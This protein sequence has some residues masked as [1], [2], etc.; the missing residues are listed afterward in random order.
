MTAPQAACLLALATLATVAVPGRA[1]EWQPVTPYRP[2][3]SS[4]AQLPYPGQLE[5]ELGGLATK[6]DGEHRNSLPYALKLAFNDN[7]GVVVGG[8]A[9]V[10]APD[11]GGG[12]T[13]GVGDTT[14]VLK[15]AWLIDSATAFGMELGAKAPT[16][17]DSIGSGRA[18]YSVNGI[19]SRD[20]D[21]VHMDANLNLTRLGVWEDGSSRTQTGVSASFS[22]PVSERW[23]MTG[24]LAG[25]RRGG[26][27]RTAQALVAAAYSPSK[28]MTIDVGL[29]KG[30]NRASADWSLFGGVV[31]PLARLW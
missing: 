8:E 12:R 24:E 29:A 28:Y 14:F 27:D 7:W 6:A 25:T 31:L 20:F 13:H 4:P 26:A 18:D 11:D 30:L 15:R 17:R 5:L 19:F 16:A 23:G 1:D 2:S 3:V 22:I 10:S 9:W 21:I